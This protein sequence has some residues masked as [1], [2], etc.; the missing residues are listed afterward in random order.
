[1]KQFEVSG[2]INKIE[3]VDNIIYIMSKDGGMLSADI[4]KL[5]LEFTI[6]GDTRDVIFHIP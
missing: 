6:T 4:T 5:P 2:N 1:M 3:I